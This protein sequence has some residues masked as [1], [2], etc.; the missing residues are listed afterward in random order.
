LTYSHALLGFY[1]QENQFLSDMRFTYIHARI[2]HREMNLKCT[3]WWWLDVKSRLQEMGF[4][5]S[6]I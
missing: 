2:R 5:Y 4:H 3:G 1:W 6:V